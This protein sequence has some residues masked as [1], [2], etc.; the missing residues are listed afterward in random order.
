MNLRQRLKQRLW[1]PILRP[2]PGRKLPPDL[3]VRAGPAAG[4]GSAGGAARS[5]FRGAP[6]PHRRVSDLRG[7]LRQGLLQ[8][9][10]DVR[11]DEG[12]DR[13]RA[14][15]SAGRVLHLQGRPDRPLL[16]R[17]A[18]PRRR[19]RRQ[20]PR[21]RRRLR[22]DRD[23]PRVLEEDAPARHR[24]PP[25]PPALSPRPAPA[26]S[27]PPQD[28]RR[29]RPDGVHGRDE[30]RRRIRIEPEEARRSVARLARAHRGAGGVGNGH[31]LHRGVGRRG[32]QP[33]RARAARA[34]D[35]RRAR[36]SSWTRA[37]S[38]G[39]ARWR[40]RWRRSCRRRGNGCGSP[41]RISRPGSAPPIC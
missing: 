1:R 19:A 3:L 5:G 21:A 30:H 38:A 28:P 7:Q 36:C 41:T 24:G 18:R 22:I 12:G 23:A 14:R 4:L 32:G 11:G 27:R 40:R 15:G 13:F 10:G 33:R 16:P 9:A 29:G 17:R 6:A 2:R 39:R 8:R 26:V 35:G 20:G 25:L 34:G 31:R 37:H